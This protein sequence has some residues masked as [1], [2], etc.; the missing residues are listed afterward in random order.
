[1][2]Q[3]WAH[4]RALLVSTLRA[5]WHTLPALLTALTLGFLGYHSMLVSAAFISDRHPWLAVVLLSLGFAS[6]LVGYLAGLQALGRQLSLSEALLTS[7][8]GTSLVREP[9]TRLVAITLL[10]FL[11]IYAVFGKVQETSGQ[12]LTYEVIT[13]GLLEKGVLTTLNPRTK[14]QMAVIL[15]VLATA[16]VIRRLLDVAHERTGRRVLGLATG[17]VETFFMLVLIYGGTRIFATGQDWVRN[18]QFSIWIENL[19]GRVAALLRHLHIDLPEVIVALWHALVGPVWEWLSSGVMAPLLWLAMTALAFGSHLLS[20]AEL[21]R[22]TVA[23]RPTRPRRLHVPL[24]RLQAVRPRPR[25]QRVAGEVKEL[26]FGDVDDKYLPTVHSLR[27][28]MSA[29]VSMLGAYILAYTAIDAIHFLV[30]QAVRGIIGPAESR[31]WVSLGFVQEFLTT[32]LA[33]PLRLSLLAVAYL[34]CLQLVNSRAH[35]P[36]PA[37]ATSPRARVGAQ[38]PSVLLAVSSIALAGAIVVRTS[39]PVYTKRVDVGFEEP[40]RVTT[41]GQQLRVV[42]MASTSSAKVSSLSRVTTTGRFLAVRLEQKTPG[43]RAAA[44]LECSLDRGGVRIDTVRSTTLAFPEPGLQVERDLLF[45]LPSADFS[46]S[47]LVCN[48]RDPLGAYSPEVHVDLG[49][50]ADGADH[51]TSFEGKT[52]EVLADR[53]P[54][55]IP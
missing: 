53:D 48:L 52:V 35:S 50:D 41:S 8:D 51:L 38:L 29:G 7:D 5:W 55:A 27:L 42:G 3:W 49:L 6:L 10:P 2:A 32:L 33:E 9:L 47:T 31:L 46:G 54:E 14:E 25:W 22:A 37:V 39:G 17:L 16:Y 24:Q 23:D 28:V 34:R 13:R 44:S 43:R 21:W 45:E 18:R 19:A 30:Q 40:V 1:M 26:F 15:A 20:M 4:V 11:G 36:A 12:L